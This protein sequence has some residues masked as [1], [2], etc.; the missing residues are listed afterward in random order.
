MQRSRCNAGGGSD[1]EEEE[2]EE[3]GTTE[4]IIDNTTKDQEPKTPDL[5]PIGKEACIDAI[6]SVSLPMLKVALVVRGERAPKLR[7]VL[8][9][10]GKEEGGYILEVAKKVVWW[11]D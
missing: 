10:M 2:S 9:P 1:L 3:A 8:P 7:L 5:P 6:D 4:P 11:L